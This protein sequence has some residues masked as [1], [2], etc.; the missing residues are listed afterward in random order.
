MRLPRIAELDEQS[1]G[2]GF[3]LCARKERR[4]GRDGGAFLSLMLQDV[5]GDVPAKVFLDVDVNDAQFDAGEF[6]AVQARGN[7]HHQRFELIVEK[8]RRVIPEDSQRGFRAEDCVPSAPRPLEE[9]W[10]EL[11]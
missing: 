3:F 5:S 11:H 10:Q 8:I 6:V 4:T 9:M 2:T 1:A 7:V